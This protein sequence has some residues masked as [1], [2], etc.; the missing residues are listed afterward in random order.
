MIIYFILYLYS[1]LA[2]V[3]LVSDILKDFKLGKELDAT[4]WH[5]CVYVCI[6]VLDCFHLYSAGSMAE[7]AKIS[8]KHLPHNRYIN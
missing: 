6:Y 2:W 5:L 3:N 8:M 1:A 7:L 4:K